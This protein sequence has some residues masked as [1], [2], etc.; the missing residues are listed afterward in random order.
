MPT[1]D[2]GGKGKKKQRICFEITPPN[3]SGDTQE[4]FFIMDVS[5]HQPSAFE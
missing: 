3:A 4:T 5:V 1:I 2:L